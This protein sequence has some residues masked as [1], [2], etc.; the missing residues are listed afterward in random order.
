MYRAAG[1]SFLVALFLLLVAAASAVEYIYSRTP[2]HAGVIALI[3]L[4]AAIIAGVVT[5]IARSLHEERK[6]RGPEAQ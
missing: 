5:F 2:G 4:S 3:A 1:I 6:S